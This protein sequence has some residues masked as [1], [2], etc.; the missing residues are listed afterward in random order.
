MGQ[1]WQALFDLDLQTQLFLNYPSEGRLVRLSLLFVCT[2]K[3][4]KAAL[5]AFFRSA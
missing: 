1:A 5:E 4:P 3:P 2:R